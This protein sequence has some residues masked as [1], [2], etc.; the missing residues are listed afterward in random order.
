VDDPAAVVADGVDAAG[1]VVDASGA[2]Y[3]YAV[4]VVI[5]EN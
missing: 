1:A 2:G 3:S 4:I 5:A